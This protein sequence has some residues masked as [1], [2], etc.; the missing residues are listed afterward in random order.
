M[1]TQK[2]EGKFKLE[3]RMK[4]TVM[5]ADFA[6]A[7]N[8][9]LYIMGGGWSI[10]GPGPSPSA[11]AIK[12]EVPWTE[13]NRSHELK[14]ELLDSDYRAVEVPMPGGN[15][16]LVLKGAFEVGRPP[17]MIQGSSMDVPIAFNIGAIPLEPGRRYVW[18]LSI[19]DKTDDNW[20]VAFSTRPSHQAPTVM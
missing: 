12:I 10:I 13:T 5:L 1:K 14:V 19:N 8:G 7:V 4:V 6:Q 16:P 15:S 3:S 2:T 11:L 20:H 18:R 9:K 17:G